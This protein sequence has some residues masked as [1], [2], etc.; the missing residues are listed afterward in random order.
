MDARRRTRIAVLGLSVGLVLADSSIVTLALPKILVQFDVEVAALAWALISFNLALALS[1]LP[2]AFVAPLAN[3]CLRRRS[4]HLCSRVAR[5]CSSPSFGALVSLRA[6]QG[7]AGA[8]VVCG[9]LDLLS[10]TMETK[11]S[12]ARVWILAG[13]I[14]ASFGPAVGGILTQLFGAESIFLVQVPL[15]LLQA[16]RAWRRRTRT[17]AAARATARL[18][19]HRPA[20][21][22][23]RARSC[24][25]PARHPP[26]NGWRIDP[27][28]AGLVVTVMPLAAIAAARFAVQFPHCGSAPPPV[29][30]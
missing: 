19:Q 11:A 7:V 29:R 6:V 16:S 28:V 30:S 20:P 5:L 26:I 22:V 3:A 2:A 12:A 21:R 10:A 18:G 8:A 24:P 9:A 23:R 14:G 1:A 15:V 13:V 4:R 17:G 27:L 25:L